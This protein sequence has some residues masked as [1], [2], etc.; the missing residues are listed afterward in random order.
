MK[1]TRMP[2]DFK[3]V[4]ITLESQDEVDALYTVLGSIV[5]AGSFNDTSVRHITSRLHAGLATCGAHRVVG[6][7]REEMELGE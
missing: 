5:G 1:V 2:D 4:V 7:V 6:T 3:P